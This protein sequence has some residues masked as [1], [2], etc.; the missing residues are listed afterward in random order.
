MTQLKLN[1][2][3]NATWVTA[4]MIIHNT[5]TPAHADAELPAVIERGQALD[6][7]NPRLAIS[8]LLLEHRQDPAT[9]PLAARDLARELAE[10]YTPPR[11][12]AS[13]FEAISL[14]LPGAQSSAVRDWA[15]QQ[16]WAKDPSDP[17][18]LLH[19]A[20]ADL[21]GGRAEEASK[22]LTKAVRI[23]PGDLGLRLAW[24]RLL[25]S[26]DRMVEAREQL[27]QA[28]ALRPGQPELALME[29]WIEI[30]DGLPALDGMAAGRARALLEPVVAS[31]PHDGEARWLLGLAQLRQDR[32]RAL[33]TLAGAAEDLLDAAAPGQRDLVPRALAALVFA[34]HPG[35][36][37]LLEHLSSGA[38]GDPWVHLFLAWTAD[39]QG[40]PGRAERQHQ[41]A[42]ETGPELARMHF[43]RAAFL[44]RDPGRAGEARAAWQRYQAL[45]P[46]GTRAN[47][48]GPAR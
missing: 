47:R 10:R 43:E 12:E 14:E 42:V 46:S 17:E 8:A 45:R 13:L 34:G 25:L 5:R 26:M 6:A 48:S 30:A 27:D 35:A 20:R 2:Y 38:A 22:K 37:R 1:Q 39:A 4:E 41:L 28:R 15:L 29:A 11:V 3:D 18:L 19:F 23:R 21:A 33:E 24:L 9:L 32:A 40:A 16:A 31:R 44:A 7:N 36:P